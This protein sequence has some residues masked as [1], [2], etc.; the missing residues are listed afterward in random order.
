MIWVPYLKIPSSKLPYHTLV[1][2]WVV[3]ET[4]SF[5]ISVLFLCCFWLT[6]MWHDLANISA[7]FITL[8]FI[9]SFIFP[10][11]TNMPYKLQY[12]GVYISLT[13]NPRTNP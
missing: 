6:I 2:H 8:D 12:K 9:K 10:Y 7:V 4:E 5:L 3:F 13:T 11:R 1:I